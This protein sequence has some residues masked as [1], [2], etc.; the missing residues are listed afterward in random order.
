M[1]LGLSL[2]LAGAC[3]QNMCCVRL[4]RRRGINYHEPWSQYG[5]SSSAVLAA[6]ACWAS[7]RRDV[8]DM[9]YLRPG[10]PLP[11]DD[12][13][14]DDFSAQSL[15]YLR[16]RNQ[17]ITRYILIVAELGRRPGGAFSRHPAR[18]GATRYRQCYRIWVLR[19]FPFAAWFCAHSASSFVFLQSLLFVLRIGIPIALPASFAKRAPGKAR[20]SVRV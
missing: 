5:S 1:I 16:L 11:R 7:R 12:S 2:D 10:A 3:L 18:V 4:L 14:L 9:G 15:S 13:D 17:V 6:V 20:L 8:A 19:A